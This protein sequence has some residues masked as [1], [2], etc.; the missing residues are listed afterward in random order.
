MV[1]SISN[2]GYETGGKSLLAG[3]NAE[4]RPGT[5]NLIVGPNGAGKTTLIKLLSGQLPPTSGTITLGGKNIADLTLPELAGIRAVLSQQTELTFPMLAWEVVMMG[6]YVHFKH[7][8][9]K[10]DYEACDECL[11]FF[12]IGNYADRE[13]HT[14]SGGEKQ[15]VQFARVLAQVWYVPEGGSR[16][17]F[18]DEPLTFLDVR[19]QHEFLDRMKELLGRG[20]T[21]IVGVL[22][23]LN[24][25][26]HFA[27]H[28][29]LLSE[30]ALLTQGKPDMVLTRDRIESAYGIPPEMFSR[31]D[32]NYIFF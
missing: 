5:F 8:P 9:S 19:F 14:L 18:L 28:I 27:D 22:H 3:I 15:R 10:R 7:N 6:R 17:L 20:D 13:Y 11:R 21:T 12:G 2:G 26:S 32:R 30:G 1:L 23:D 29:L 16:I 24:M 25:V 4:F 31:G